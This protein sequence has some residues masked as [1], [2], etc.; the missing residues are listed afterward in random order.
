MRDYSILGIGHYIKSCV[1][2][3]VV[4]SS[5][6][7][8]EI[9][10]T[11]KTN[12]YFAS[13]GLLREEDIQSFHLSLINALYDEYVSNNLIEFI[14]EISYSLRYYSTKIRSTPNQLPSNY[15]KHKVNDFDIF[16]DDNF[17]LF[18]YEDALVYVLMYDQ[19]IFDINDYC[20]NYKKLKNINFNKIWKLLNRWKVFL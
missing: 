2:Y 6:K 12:I 10:Q 1:E 14:D 5:R 20:G 16:V 13:R 8:I 17:T 18:Y 11:R 9:S 7:T 19:C 3:D 15:K 4:I